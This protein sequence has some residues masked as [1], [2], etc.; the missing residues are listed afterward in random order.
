[1]I[2]KRTGT[3]TERPKVK[4]EEQPVKEKKKS[5]STQSSSAREYSI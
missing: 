2:A 1:V 3:Y 4:K 5:S